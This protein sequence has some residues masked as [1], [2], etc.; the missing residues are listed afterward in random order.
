MRGKFI[1][2]DHKYW[3]KEAL[4]LIEPHTTNLT[5]VPVSALIVKENQIVSKAINLVES[6]S[7]ATAHAEM[8]AIRGASRTIGNWRLLGCTLYTT[9]EPCVM[10]AGAIMQARITRLVFGAYDLK[11]GACGSVFNL[12]KEMKKTNHTEIIGGVLELECSQLLSDFFAAK[13]SVVIKN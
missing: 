2:H 9:L 11:G 1:K 4:K 10:C 6:C 13:R 3:I 7:D 8:L 5:E 12:F